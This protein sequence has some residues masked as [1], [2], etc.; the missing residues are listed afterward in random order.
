LYRGSAEA[1]PAAVPATGT[2]P[3]T[4]VVKN[5][6][7]PATDGDVDGRSPAGIPTACLYTSVT[8]GFSGVALV[9]AA[10]SIFV[11][12]SITVPP[13]SFRPYMLKVPVPNVLDGELG[14]MSLPVAKK[15]YCCVL[16]SH[17]SADEA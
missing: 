13:L 10:M 16:P 4:V 1:T 9:T 7:S 11:N 5:T 17:I 2:P 3:S 15:M 8:I 14:S 12:A 6:I